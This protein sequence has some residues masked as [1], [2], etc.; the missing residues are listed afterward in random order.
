L[1]E[2]WANMVDKI[3]DPNGVVQTDTATMLSW[4]LRS[5]C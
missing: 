1:A 4:H 5:F 2:F 3:N